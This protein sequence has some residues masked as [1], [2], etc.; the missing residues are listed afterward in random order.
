MDF[1]FNGDEIHLWLALLDQPET[2]LSF[3][4][5]SLS[6][7]E[8][9]RANRYR[10]EHDRQRFIARRGILRQ[11]TGQ[12][13]NIPAAQIKF[14]YSET[15]K[16]SI[17]GQSLKFNLSHSGEYGYYAI[18]H[19]RE[20]GVDIEKIRN[21]NDL[22]LIAKRF[23]SGVENAALLHLSDDKKVPAFYHVWTQKEA[24]VKALGTGLSFPLANFDVSVDPAQ[25][26]GLLSIRDGAEV[27]S[28]W[29]MQTYLPIEGFQAAVCYTG[30]ET[31]LRVLA[32]SQE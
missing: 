26:G 31:N 28:N 4:R 15:G 9:E 23:F 1:N 3:W 22:T 14:A 25:P 30:D 8:L 13:L 20:L 2:C 12:Y 6:P 16:P 17:K 29:H 21:I 32:F 11:L 5:A 10:F 18:A 7:D 24:F 19:N 27:V